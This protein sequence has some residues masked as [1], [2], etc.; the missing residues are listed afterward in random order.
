MLSAVS[1]ELSET[2]YNVFAKTE[3]DIVDL[4]FDYDSLE[5]LEEKWF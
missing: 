5:L 2:F 1:E 3:G 4:I